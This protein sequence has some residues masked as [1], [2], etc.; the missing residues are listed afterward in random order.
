MVGRNFPGFNAKERRT[1]DRAGSRRFRV[2]IFEASHPSNLNMETLT[3]F[4]N[5]AN[6]FF[7]NARLDAM[8]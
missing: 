7:S 6:P 5:N 2:P 3:P 4:S 1:T 8:L